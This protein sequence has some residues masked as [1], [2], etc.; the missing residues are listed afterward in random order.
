MLTNAKGNSG[1][2]VDIDYDQTPDVYFSMLG[3]RYSQVQVDAGNDGIADLVALLDSD[4]VYRYF[5]YIP[6]SGLY[7]PVALMGV[8]KT[9][10]RYDKLKP[11]I[12]KAVQRRI[13][14]DSKAI[15]LKPAS[16]SVFDNGF[17]SELGGKS[18]KFTVKLTLTPPQI[19]YD[20]ERNKKPAPLFQK[21]FSLKPGKQETDDAGVM[22][23]SDDLLG[24]G[25][26]KKKVDLVVS[27]LLLNV[28]QEG[29]E[30]FQVIQVS[31]LLA[32]EDG[33]F[34]SF[35]TLLKTSKTDG[36]LSTA[37]LVDSLGKDH[38]AVFIE[39]YSP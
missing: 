31:G 25:R 39:L 29:S 28:A 9:D 2:W 3:S 15:P 16:P 4:G 30:P 22:R 23:I 37:P 18:E 27:I 36:A 10:G 12:T 38:G 14:L 5:G 32:I 17:Y 33:G 35:C 21:Q 19:D 8:A 11:M 34:T 13:K 20:P 1:F 7:K 26:P 24:E 6:E